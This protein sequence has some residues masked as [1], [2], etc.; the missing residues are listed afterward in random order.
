LPGNGQT[1][2]PPGDYYLG[3]VSQGVNPSGQ[4][5]GSNTTSYVLS[6]LGSLPVTDLGAVGSSDLVITNAL[7]AADVAAYHFVNVPKTV[8]AMEVRLEN[9]AGNPY[10][11][12]LNGTA[13]PGFSIG[14]SYAGGEGGQRA[15]WS[16]STLITLPNAAA[17]TYTLTIA[18]AAASG[19]YPDAAYTLRIHQVVP[20]PINLAPSQ[21]AN[22]GTNAVS[23]SLA[24][25]ESAYYQVSITNLDGAPLLGWNLDL[26]VTN[27]AP[28][29][30]VRPG[31]LPD[32]TCDTTAFASGSVIVAPPYLTNG[33]WY[34]EV[35]GNGASTFSL[36]SSAI[37]TNTLT[38][39][40]WVMP[41]AG[42]TTVAAAGLSM[43]VFGDTGVSSSGTNLPGDQGVD[44]ANGQYHFY[45][46]VVPDHN[47]G[48][49][50]TELEA[51]SGNPNLYVRTGA[52]PTLYHYSRGSCPVYYGEPPLVDRQLSAS[53]DTEYGNW[54]PLD[55][56]TETQLTPGLWVLAVQATGSSN[57]RYRLILSSGNVVTNGLV[58]PLPLDGSVT[59]S[60]SFAGHDWQYYRVDFPSN[61][62]ATLTVNWTRSQGDAHLFIR[63]TVPPG[64]GASGSYYNYN[65]SWGDAVTWAS[66]AKN[67]G[68][69]PNFPSPGAAVLTV[70]PLRPGAIY[71]LGFWSDNDTTI[72][73]SCS[74]NGAVDLAGDIPFYAG[75]VGASVPANSALLYRIEVPAEATRLK[76]YATNAAGLILT[77][78]Q[79]T[80]ALPGGPAHWKSS[81][82]NAGL[83]QPLG[84]VWPWLPGYAYYL[85]VTNTSGS[86]EPFSLNL[87]LPAH[88]APN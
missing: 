9:V 1:N 61:A 58:E 33:A 31:L 22:G 25:G 41:A 65:S 42:D 82:A 48:L 5:I 39:Q 8:A 69:Y 13:V 35:R 45:A 43:P 71:Y 75:G 86:A 28:E 18:A 62:P 10:M 68:P 7:E 4:D 44:L 57:A 27:G 85:T 70:P 47:A 55:G 49:L 30:R 26:I 51:I 3:V 59:N 87:A 16:A 11:Y 63:D 50:R 74:T 67:K 79:G 38:R 56:Q 6:C 17:G 83:D 72:S 54:V 73:V 34:V 14:Y 60:N 23:G 81:G 2:I 40:P 53:A 76:F 21:N 66:D 29:M 20:P 46:V 36:V 88:Q 19:V 78:E 80:V 12:L 77:L 37:T 52:A 15:D 24:D 64:D 32:D 84:S